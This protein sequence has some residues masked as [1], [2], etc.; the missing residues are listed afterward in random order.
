M[1]QIDQD[2]G[3]AHLDHGGHGV[4]GDDEQR[5]TEL[6]HAVAND[7]QCIAANLGDGKKEYPADDLGREYDFFKADAFTPLAA[8]VYGKD[9][10]EGGRCEEHAYLSVRDAKAV[11]EVWHQD[12]PDAR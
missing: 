8:I 5:D 10:E 6:N 9:A 1:N 2:G 3:V 4:Q 12:P 11:N 7:K